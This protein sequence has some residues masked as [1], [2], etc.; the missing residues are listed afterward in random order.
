MGI[1]LPGPGSNGYG[2]PQ[3]RVAAAMAEDHARIRGERM[4]EAIAQ[5]NSRIAD[6]A[7]VI[8]WFLSKQPEGSAIQIPLAELAALKGRVLKTTPGQVPDPRQ[9]AG[10]DGRSP[11]IDVAVISSHPGEDQPKVIVARPTEPR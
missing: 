8:C 9:P 1:M 3:N 7:L 5:Q 11:M 10:E 4:A 6:L 2:Q